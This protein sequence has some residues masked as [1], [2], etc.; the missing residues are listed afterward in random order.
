M[1]IILSIFL[2]IACFKWWSYKRMCEG[3]MFFA[4]K[5]HDWKINEDEVKKILEYSIKRNI[6]G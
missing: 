5:D 2:I 4:M 6:I 3:L 1:I